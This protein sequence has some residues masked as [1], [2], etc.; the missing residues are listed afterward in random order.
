MFVF[1]KVMKLYTLFLFILQNCTFDHVNLLATLLFMH[2]Y[3]TCV[4]QIFI[5]M[6]ETPKSEVIILNYIIGCSRESE[7]VW[8]STDVHLSDLSVELHLPTPHVFFSLG[9]HG[10]PYCPDLML[11]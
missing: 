9:L 8:G 6:F 11:I 1:V 4:S 3:G 5:N 2:I 10:P 7:E